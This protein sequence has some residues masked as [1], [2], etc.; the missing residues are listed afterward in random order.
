MEGR[1]VEKS[2]AFVMTL[3][4]EVIESLALLTIDPF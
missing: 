2:N 4:G 1:E 3:W